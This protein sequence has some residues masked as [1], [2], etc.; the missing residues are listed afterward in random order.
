MGKIKITKIHVGFKINEP[1]PL[2]VEP[3]SPIEGKIIITNNGTKD[4]KLKEVAVELYE[5]FEEKYT[6]DTG[7]GYK[8]VK[9]NYGR[10]PSK[11]QGIIKAGEEQI[12]DFKFTLPRWKRTKGKKIYSWRMELWFKQKTKMMSTRGSIRENATCVLPVETTEVVP[13]FGD[14]QTVLAK[15]IKKKKY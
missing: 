13:H 6:D 9:N 10:Y 1:Y 5:V 2:F 11:T 4:Q 7:I 15:K 12:Y 3:G 8:K 14:S